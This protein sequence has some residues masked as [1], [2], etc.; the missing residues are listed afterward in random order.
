MQAKTPRKILDG[1]AFNILI[2]Q[3][4]LTDTTIKKGATLK[5]T[6]RFI[7]D[8]VKQCKWQTKKLA[9]VLKGDSVIKTCENIW[10]FLYSHV[11]FHKDKE[12]KEQ[13]RSP[14]RSWHDRET[15]I[16]CDCYTIFISTLLTNLGIPHTLRITKYS[17]PGFQHIYPIVPTGN[18]KYITIDCVTD[19]FN[20]EEPYT[21]KEDTPMDLEFLEGFDGNDNRN[22]SNDELGKRGWFKRFTHGAL[23]AFNRFNPATTMLRNGILASMKL[24]LFKVAQRLKYAYLNEQQAKAHKMD[25]DK[26]RH[27][28]SVKDKLENIFYGAGGK[29][30]NFKHSILK[31]KGNHNHDVNGLGFT[32]D[33][34][35]F[36]FD[37]ETPLPQLLG[38]AIFESEND[39]E[40]M[41]ELGDPVTGAS[42][43]A[44]TGIMGII[45]KLL[46]QLGNPFAKKDEAGSEDFKTTKADDKAATDAATDATATDNSKVDKAAD[47][48]APGSTDK[49][50]ADTTDDSKDGKTPPGTGFWAKNKKWLKPT[51]FGTAGLGALLG[52][53]ALL[54][55]EKKHA[56]KPQES[57]TGLEGVKKKKEKKHVALM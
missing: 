45:A 37:I 42:I 46:K 52:G 24:N 12:Y 2:P 36:G 56:K 32:P 43:G 23:H 21:A 10:D 29:P 5:D 1:Q 31:G 20:Y 7:P 9:E 4:K 41:G 48:P 57:L 14:A 22:N 35:V 18:G 55:E 26:W 8:A 40:G 28:V 15:G 34:E 11:R 30:V 50:D 47:T 17:G 54:K 16:D 25:M 3:A 44:A 6:I 51:I 13:I 39:L 33:N 38:K 19:K 49:T 53:Y 27:L